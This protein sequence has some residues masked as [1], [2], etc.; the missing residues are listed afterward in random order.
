MLIRF[1]THWCC[2]LLFSTINPTHPMGMALKFSNKQTRSEY[3]MKHIE[4]VGSHAGCSTFTSE[5]RMMGIWWW[6]A[7]PNNLSSSS[8]LITLKLDVAFVDP[9]V[10]HISFLTRHLAQKRFQNQADSADL[11]AAEAPSKCVL[12]NGWNCIFV[13][14]L[15]INH[16][17]HPCHSTTRRQMVPHHKLVSE[18]ANSAQVFF[19]VIWEI[20]ELLEY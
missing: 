11:K 13:P 2:L 20:L 9:F 8:A 6:E 1:Q 17:V 7:G 16:I 5:I 14:M 15:N 4:T 12:L 3:I 10:V 19:R 18:S